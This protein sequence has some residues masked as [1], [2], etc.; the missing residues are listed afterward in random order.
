MQKNH[1]LSLIAIAIFVISI[2]SCKKDAVVTPVVV[3]TPSQLLISGS[4]KLSAETE[5]GVDSYTKQPA[6]DKDDFYNY[7]SAGKFT[8]DRG[9]TKCDAADDQTITF[10][11][12]MSADGK[13]ITFKSP[14]SDP[15]DAKVIELT[16]TTL[17]TQITALGSVLV[18][19]YSKK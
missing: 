2:A 17:K 8:Q 10:D 19:T 16:A 6:C 4:W 13:T 3:L 5:D 9:T 15:F 11:Y 12:T 14:G 7:T 18:S 1:F